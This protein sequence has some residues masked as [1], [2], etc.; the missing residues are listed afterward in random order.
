MLLTS[1]SITIFGEYVV[2][3]YFRMPGEKESGWHDVMNFGTRQ[4]DAIEACRDFEKMEAS[5]LQGLIKKFNW[6]RM[7]RRSPG[8][9]APQRGGTDPKDVQ[10]SG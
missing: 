5:R 1:I 9:Y 6:R 4:G 7:Y 2:E 10:S 3:A 8:N